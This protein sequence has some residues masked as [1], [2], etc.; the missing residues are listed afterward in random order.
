MGTRPC[1]LFGIKQILQKR[2][3]RGLDRISFGRGKCSREN[4]RFSVQADFILFS[5]DRGV[6]SRVDGP[7]HDWLKEEIVI[8][9][10]CVMEVT[11]V[12]RDFAIFAFE[13]KP[14][15]EPAERMKSWMT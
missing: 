6:E 14:F 13:G 10:S 12:A 9:F 5:R 1:Q 11:S 3:R 4:C 7:F 2:D 8:I 15:I